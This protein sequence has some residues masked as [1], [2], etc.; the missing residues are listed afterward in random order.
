MEGNAF[1][2]FHRGENRSRRI[3]GIVNR[4][5]KT[6]DFKLSDQF[7]SNTNSS[8]PISR[9]DRL[10]GSSV[11][12][13]GYEI[14]P[15]E[16]LP[17][18]S[19]WGFEF[20]AG[21]YDQT[22]TGH[23]TS[24]FNF[25]QADPEGALSFVCSY[26]PI[27][28]VSSQKNETWG[29]GFPISVPQVDTHSPFSSD[30]P[31][32]SYYLTGV[33]SFPTTVNTAI[34]YAKFDNVYASLKS[35]AFKG[36]SVYATTSVNSFLA[37]Q[38]PL[39]L[40]KTLLEDHGS[41]T[42][43]SYYEQRTFT[44]IAN[45]YSSNSYYGVYGYNA[46]YGPKIPLVDEVNT[47]LKH[48]KAT[49]WVADNGLVKIKDYDRDVFGTYEQLYTVTPDDY[50]SFEIIDNPLGVTQYQSQRASE[51]NLLYNY[52]YTRKKHL[53]RFVDNKANN[54]FCDSAY[55]AG[56][57][58]NIEIQDKYIVDSETATNV[59]DSYTRL[60]TQALTFVNMR[61]PA[62]RF[63]I[64]I[65]DMLYL[66]HPMIVGSQDLFFTTN[67]TQDYQNGYVDI[68]AVKAPIL[69]TNSLVNEG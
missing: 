32:R 63:N 16:T 62:Y 13:V 64:E 20:T 8:W 29:S 65:A 12:T 36:W 21:V 38:N 25:T 54:S 2:G 47:M 57:L 5:E 26:G 6:D 17:I 18:R 19:L 27:T 53:D 39:L 30:Y 35:E 51:I 41:V 14:L 45:R 37:N 31:E 7:S 34:L 50:M 22:S 10:K 44:S 66:Q 69:F 23:S 49:G 58:D 40:V 9:S 60:Y 42:V 11:F 3:G 1:S 48:V 15:S 67:V 52:S 43:N 61:L 28:F 46:I 4:I 33:T 55:T 59:L 68:T 24:Y 56:I